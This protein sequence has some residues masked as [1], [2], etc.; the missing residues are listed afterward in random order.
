MG[1]PFTRRVLYTT[2]RNLALEFGVAEL[3]DSLLFTP[4][5]MYLCLEIVPNLQL[6]V[7]L[8]EVASN[9]AFYTT[10]MIMHELRA[11]R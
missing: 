6:A 9:A 7:V 5:L 10:A 11:T 8:S 1:L 4:A 2:S 3:L